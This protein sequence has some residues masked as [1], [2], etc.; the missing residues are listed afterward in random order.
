MTIDKRISDAPGAS[1]P[2]TV[3]VGAPLAGP[4]VVTSPIEAHP[5]SLEE[6][7]LAYLREPGAVA[8]AGPA[9]ER[10]TT[11]TEVAR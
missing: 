9:Y 10:R 11:V 8:L 2:G 1:Q 3:G 6:L 5:V 7:V 4:D